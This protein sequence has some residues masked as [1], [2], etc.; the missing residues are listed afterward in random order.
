[1]ALVLNE[2][3]RMLK[4][5]AKDFLS[6]TMPVAAL[7]Q[8]RDSGEGQD[9]NSDH[10]QQ[11]VELGWAGIVLPEQ[12]GGLDFGYQGLGAIIEESGRRLAASPLISNIVLC[13]SAL[14]LA[15]N[16]AQKDRFL[17]AIASGD[18][19]LALALD[20]GNHHDPAATALSVKQEGSQYQLNGRK[21]MVMEGNSADHFIVLARS[22]GMPGDTSGLS[23]FLLGVDQPGVSRESRCI[24]DSR[25]YATVNFDQ[26]TVDADALLGE[27]DQAWPILE[28]VLDRGRICL[29][30]EML[31]G[32]LECFERTV[33]YLKER[34]QFGVKIGT[35]QA[36]QH[37]AAIMFTELEL[38]K[39]AVLDALS[40]IDDGRPDAPQLASLAKTLANDVFQ[41]VSTE[42]VQMHGG[43]G[44]TDELDIG[45]FLKR[46]RS[47]TELLGN[48]GFHRDRYASLCGY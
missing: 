47:A 17:P 12:Y 31:G 5:S 34:E 30:A 16:D 48:S 7:R 36:L 41:L 40:A 37:R 6:A 35:F 20:E 27:W 44:V 39:S 3:Q 38:C 10:W 45:L 22:S 42:S 26:V 19:T 15:G 28:Q 2:E 23:L 46:C 43:I 21:V 24:L 14:L 8:L 11:M 13:S 9:Y 33:E 25:G 1:M 32:A 29:A 4:D 18:L